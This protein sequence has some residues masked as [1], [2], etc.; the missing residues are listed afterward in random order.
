[1][2]FTVTPELATLL[3]TLRAQSGV[4]A[5]DLASHLKRSPSYVSKLESGFLKSVQE[6]TLTDMLVYISEGDDFYGEVLPNVFRV[7]EAIMD[8]QRLVAQSWFLQ[9]DVVER[10]VPVSEGMVDD[11]R[12]QMDRLDIGAGELSAF[13]DG[14]FDSEL[15][16]DFPVN[17]IV[18]LEYEGKPRLTYRAEVS[19]DELSRFLR[20]KVKDCRYMFLN[21][22]LFALFRMENYPD[23]EGRLP[24]DEA[25]V[26]LRC[27]AD[28]MDQQ[29]IHSLASFSHMLS[30]ES[31]IERQK[32]LLGGRA[33][34]PSRIAATLQEV[35]DADPLTTINQL[36]V[37]CE[38]LNWDPAFAVSLMS[39]PFSDLG[40]MSHR[41][42]ARLLEDVRALVDSY[43]KLPDIQKKI[44]HY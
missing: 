38:T 41:N 30:S 34:V 33:D 27:M 22:V 36:N 35:V 31:F 32:V 44:E 40:S 15:S 7:L 14:N 13:V 42:K 18:V 2:K 8:P 9:Y 19:E 37:F 25:T 16:D 3:K 29:G 6:D 10:R 5:K 12:R 23:V 20:K 26:V 4:S 1:M 17:Q 11:I 21:N 43:E 28:Y 24:P 39:I